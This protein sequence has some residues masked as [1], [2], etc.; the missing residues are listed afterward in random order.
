[1]PEG[2]S[3]CKK[4]GLYYFSFT[5]LSGSFSIVWAKAGMA[6]LSDPDQEG[7]AGTLYP[8]ILHIPKGFCLGP[9][10]AEI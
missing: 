9:P 2:A 10:T 6:I 7:M 4:T 8:S 5:L 1:M 3:F